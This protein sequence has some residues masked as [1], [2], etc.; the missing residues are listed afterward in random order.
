MLARIGKDKRNGCVSFYH[1]L[2]LSPKLRMPNPLNLSTMQKPLL[3]HS[4][5]PPSLL[6]WVST[7]LA[8]RQWL[9]EQSMKL[10]GLLSLPMQFH[11]WPYCANRLWIGLFYMRFVDLFLLKERKCFKSSS[12]IVSQL[13]SVTQAL[14]HTCIVLAWPPTIHVPKTKLVVLARSC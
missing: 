6:A 14:P 9:F 8:P 7:A 2:V 1:P 12:A 5:P 4:F 10:M 13:P 11:A 3:R